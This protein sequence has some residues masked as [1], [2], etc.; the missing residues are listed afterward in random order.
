MSYNVY[1]TNLCVILYTEP[2]TKQSI[3][4]NKVCTVI[5]NITLP[6]NIHWFFASV[7]FKYVYLEMCLKKKQKS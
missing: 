7:H 3:D 4:L 2:M 5:V 1:E 6:A